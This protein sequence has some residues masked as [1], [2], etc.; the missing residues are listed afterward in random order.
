MSMYHRSWEYARV[1]DYHRNLE[2]NWSYTPTYL[3]KLDL[4]RRFIESRSPNRKIVDL[5][6]GEGLLVEEFR[7][8]GWEIEGLDLNYESEFVRRGDVRKLPYVDLSTGSV[9]FLDTL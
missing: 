5:A 4:A 6:C 9:L 8:R 2:P 1:G 3:R 7:Q